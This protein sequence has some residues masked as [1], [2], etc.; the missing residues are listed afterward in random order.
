MR[1]PNK[2]TINC[3]IHDV[4]PMEGPKGPYVSL[5]LI[6]NDDEF[7]DQTLWLNL[8]FSSRKAVEIS[9][10]VLERLGFEG[11]PSDIE[12][13]FSELKDKD[14]DFY[15]QHDSYNGEFKYRVNLSRKEIACPDDWGAAM[16]DKLKEA[17]VKTKRVDSFS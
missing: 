2:T 5:L 16:K 15:V 11:D 14:A 3:N 1:I 7:D 6:P 12:A 13:L 10:N 4:R 17:G 9:T 8:F